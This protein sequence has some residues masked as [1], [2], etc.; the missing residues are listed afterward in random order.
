MSRKG[1]DKQMKPDPIVREYQRKMILWVAGW[2]AV[3]ISMLIFADYSGVLDDV[4]EW[5]RYRYQLLRDI[6]GNFLALQ[7][8]K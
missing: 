5:M 7:T 2:G 1:E 6:T 8:W 3:A 4:S